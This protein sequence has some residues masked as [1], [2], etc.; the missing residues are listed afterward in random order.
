MLL[1]CRLIECF[2][3][4]QQKCAG[5]FPEY[6]GWINSMYL[7]LQETLEDI[8]R[9][10]L[11][12]Q[13]SLHAMLHTAAVC[14]CVLTAVHAMQSSCAVC[15]NVAVQSQPHLVFCSVTGHCLNNCLLATGK[16]RRQ[17]FPSLL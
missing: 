12:E 3:Q 8:Q 5:S 15:T 16:L 13:A 14:A 4:E 11:S 10:P 9:L 7:G 2:K 17:L 1:P 6:S